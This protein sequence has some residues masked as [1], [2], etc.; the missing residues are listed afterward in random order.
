MSSIETQE[1]RVR[2]YHATTNALPAH[3]L[4]TSVNTIGERIAWARKQRKL[5]QDALAKRVGISQSAIGS[6]EAGHRGK[7]RELLSIARAL[8]VNPVWLEKG[9]GEWDLPPSMNESHVEQLFEELAAARG[10]HVHTLRRW[11]AE[12]LP[13]WLRAE[14]PHENYMPD[15]EIS[16]P[17]ASPIYVD[18]KFKSDEVMRRPSTAPLVK[19]AQAHPGEFTLFFIDASKDDYGITEF[20]SEIG[21]HDFVP[22]SDDD[23]GHSIA[24]FAR[25]SSPEPPPP[26]APGIWRVPAFLRKREVAEPP[27]VVYS[28]MQ[29][30]RAWE[31]EDELPDGEFV[32]VPRLEVHL[33]AG[34]GAGTSQVDIE[35]NEKQPQ[36]FRA[37]W[38]RQQHLKPKKLA[39]MTARGNSMEPTI[40]DGDSLLV[41]TSQ[42]EVIDG[43]CMR[44]G[45]RAAS[46]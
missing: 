46:A 28:T 34:A 9:E 22:A 45:T 23:A 19:L 29:P 39:A 3:P 44:C 12:A 41:D 32:M 24:A 11:D 25:G 36:A 7:P 18:L 31:H 35:F 42:A 4:I 38:I 6:Y 15:I 37:E 40:H 26:A 43:R 30:I 5:T 8:D 16:R 1:Y 14:A 21:A 2:D 33:S 20:L 10:M 27:A 17:G 13:E